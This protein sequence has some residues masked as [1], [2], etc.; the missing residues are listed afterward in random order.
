VAA[1]ESGDESPESAMAAARPGVRAA[2]VGGGRRWGAG[3]IGGVL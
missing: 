1:A 3:E 2:R